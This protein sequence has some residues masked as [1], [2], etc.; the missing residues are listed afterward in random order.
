[1]FRK[2]INEEYNGWF[3]KEKV[4]E[5]IKGEQKVSFKANMGTA[6]H[7]ILEHGYS[8]Y[9]NKESELYEVTVKERDQPD[10][11]FVFTKTE[12][13]PVMD[14][15]DIHSRAVNEIPMQLTFEVSG[16]NLVMNMKV[17]SMLGVA[18][19][20]HKTSDKEPKHDDFER[21]LQWKLYLL[22][23]EAKIFTYNHFQYRRLNRGKGPLEIKRREWPLY[24]YEGMYNDVVGWC[25]RFINFCREEELFDYIQ[26]RE[27][28]PIV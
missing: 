19:T 18:V 8:K 11:L 12:L 20:D 23:T 2:H 14:Y 16:Y 6:I 21:S 10:E 17:D 15:V 9:F 26:L 27:P 7:S 4:I 28:R 24:P 22:A 1:M 25:M 3:T 13:Q 5:Q